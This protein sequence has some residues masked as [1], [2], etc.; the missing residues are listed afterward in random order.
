MV[1][2][3]KGEIR[4][5]SAGLLAP[6]VLPELWNGGQVTVAALRDYFT[7]GRTVRVPH[8]GYDETQVVPACAEP[9][10]RDAVRQ[11]V[12]QGAVWLTNG[13]AS[14][15]KEQIPYGVLDGAAILHPPPNPVAAQEL[16]AEALPGAWRDGQ[17]NGVALTQALSQSR[18][19]TLPW[20]LV[21][22]GIRAGVESRWLEIADG[23]A[24]VGCPYDQAGQLRLKRPAALVDPPPPPAR[25]CRHG[26]AARRPPDPRPRGV[27]AEAAGGERRQRPPL[28]RRRG[29]ERR[30]RPR[31]R[32]RG[33][34]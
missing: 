12:E 25:P 9:A 26:S 11:A 21:R 14:V 6:G 3:V 23:S 15:W 31:R 29:A 7:G 8:E 5:L 34:G 2:P 28:P 18:R 4:A 33:L 17:T 13:P 27:A 32:P 10:V 1:L 19:T 16:A 22:D 30:R 24:P 20:G